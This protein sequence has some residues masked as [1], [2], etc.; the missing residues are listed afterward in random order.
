M[1]QQTDFNKCKLIE[2]QLTGNTAE[3]EKCR[4]FEAK[5]EHVYDQF[6]FW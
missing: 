2:Y 1:D 3:E 6:Q 5:T 4:Q